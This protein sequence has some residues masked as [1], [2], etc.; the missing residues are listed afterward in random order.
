M[1]RVLAF[2]FLIV[3]LGNSCIKK[4]TKDPVPVIEFLDF[5]NPGKSA[6]TGRDTALIHISYED[7]DGDLFTDFKTDNNNFIF[8]PFY[9]NTSTNQFYVVIDPITNDTTRISYT[10]VQP[11]NGYYKGKSI[12]G[13][14]FVPLNQFRPNDDVKILKFKGFMVDMSGHK[15]NVVESPTYTLNF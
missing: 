12:K 11:D 10:I 6:S 1:T 9:F 15:S 5:L 14:I 8:T 7:G 4:K 2:I 3:L 13:E